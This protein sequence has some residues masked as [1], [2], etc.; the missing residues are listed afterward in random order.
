MPEN[1]KFEA[2]LM[3]KLEKGGVDKVDLRKISSSIVGLKNQG[4]VID[5]VFIKGKPGFSRV[6]IYG[7]VDP[8]FLKK[9]VPGN[10]PLKR[11]EVF[12]FGIIN[13][14]GFNFKGTVESY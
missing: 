4:L 8:E 3:A 12:P 11:F 5:Q 14:E 1:E 6:H 13:P 9:M 7:R 10:T 2:A